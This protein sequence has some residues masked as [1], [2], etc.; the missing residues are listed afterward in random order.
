MRIIDLSHL[1]DNNT[2]VYPGSVKPEFNQVCSIV[3]DGFAESKIAMLSHVGTHIDAPAHLIEGAKYLDELEID[4]F[5][6][7]AFCIDISNKNGSN[8]ELTDLLPYSDKIKASEFLLFY[9]GWAGKWLEQTYFEG[10]PVLTTQA[11]KWLCESK[12]KGIGLD[13]ISIDP[14]GSVTLPVHHIMLENDTLII[15][16]LKI[17]AELS[18]KE[19]Y[20]SCFPL[21][22]YHSDGAPV[23]AVA[24]L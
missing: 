10:F 2:P 3:S 7:K 18:G 1:L 20:F 21:K 24:F 4:N 16:N 13:C 12:P 14:V 15:E 8:I 5:C 19:F 23:R 17:P 6:G 22:Y 9:T 11:A